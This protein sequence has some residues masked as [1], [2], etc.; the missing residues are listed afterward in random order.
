ME[1][2][3]KNEIKKTCKDNNVKP[4]EDKLEKMTY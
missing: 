2:E 1:Q 4:D 3:I